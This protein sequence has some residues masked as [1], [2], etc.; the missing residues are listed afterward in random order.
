METSVDMGEKAK[1]RLETL[2][3]RGPWGLAG[4]NIWS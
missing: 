2:E 1:G 4:C 3:H